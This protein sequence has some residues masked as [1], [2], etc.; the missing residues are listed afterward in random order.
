M[1]AAYQL[2]QQQG[3]TDILEILDDTSAPSVL[4]ADG[5]L[6]AEAQEAI[7]QS[8]A[9]FNQ[10]YTRS[11]ERIEYYPHELLPAE[12]SDTHWTSPGEAHGRVIRA[13]DS[14]ES[15]IDAHHYHSVRPGGRSTIGKGKLT[16]WGSVFAA[17]VDAVIHNIRTLQVLPPHDGQVDPIS[18][19][20]PSS[21][22]VQQFLHL[23]DMGFVLEPYGAVHFEV[24]DYVRPSTLSTPLHTQ[25]KKTLK[26]IKGA[27]VTL[28]RQR[29]AQEADALF[30]A[31]R[32]QKSEALRQLTAA[33]GVEACSPDSKKMRLGARVRAQG[34]RELLAAI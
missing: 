28:T 15:R 16:I 34:L 13:Q 25:W 1:S 5:T 2:E 19:S 26:Q 29:N 6:P 30:A 4:A 7:R 24:Y 22:A 23:L 10:Q 17:E 12:K 8:A 9:F 32:V 18:N 3:L 27:L 20:T 21:A 14:E 33:P 11:L 31:H